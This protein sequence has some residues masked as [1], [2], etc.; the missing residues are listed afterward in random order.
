[1]LV[2]FAAAVV[3]LLVEALVLALVAIVAVAVRLSWGHWKCEVVAPNSERLI[4]SAGSL[5]DAMALAVV[6]SE[7]VE[8]DGNVDPWSGGG[9]V[10][11]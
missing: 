7:S 9:L 3:V 2:F 5:G 1:M 8:M 11:V 4:V 10:G 6:L